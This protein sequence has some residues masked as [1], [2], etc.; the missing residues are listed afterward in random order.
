MNITRNDRIGMERAHVHA[1]PPLHTQNIDGWLWR[2][3]GG[4]SQRANS[5]ST[6][7]FTGND[8][9]GAIAAVCGD[10]GLDADVAEGLA[11]ISRVPGLIAHALEEKSRHTPMRH[12]DPGRHRYD[13]PSERRLRERR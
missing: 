6:I 10:L 11:M 4:G 1:W 12:I 8:P 5:V 7:D 9:D 13:G 2:S 3:S